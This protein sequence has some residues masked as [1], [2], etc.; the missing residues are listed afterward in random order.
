MTFLL[1][2]NVFVW[3]FILSLAGISVSRWKSQ[4]TGFPAA[5]TASVL[6]LFSFFKLP[7]LNLQPL[8]L[9]GLD[10]LVDVAPILEPL[11]GRLGLRWAQRGVESFG[12]L[13]PFFEPRGW[14]TL[15]LVANKWLMPAV[16]FLG[17]LSFSLTLFL[18]WKPASKMAGSILM[19]SSAGNLLFLFYF[20]P[21]IDGLGERA[22]PSVF[23][24]AQPLLGAHIEWVGPLAMIA[25]LGLMFAAGAQAQLLS[26]SS[27]ADELDDE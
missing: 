21:D 20:L 12:L 6:L 17:A 7:W 9:I 2:L 24:L 1:C 10:W 26:E 23:G 19:A 11:L 15:L 27:L 5:G 3:L 22:F 25:A 18:L 16:M 14:L 8:K 4:Q 13:E